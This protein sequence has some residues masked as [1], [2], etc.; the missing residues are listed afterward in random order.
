MVLGLTHLSFENGQLFLSDLANGKAAYYLH[1][2]RFYRRHDNTAPILALIANRSD[3][4]LVQFGG[5]S[6]YRRIPGYQVSLGL[7]VAV[8]TALLMLGSVLSAVFWIPRKL[9]GDLK[10]APYFSVRADPLL[11]TLSGVALCGLIWVMS[12]DSYARPGGPLW[13]GRTAVVIYYIAHAAFLSFSVGGL[14]RALHY[15]HKPISPLVWWHA[16]TLSLVLSAAAGYLVYGGL[17][18]VFTS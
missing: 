5:G 10:T 12:G 14:I 13:S 6:T 3:G 8:G 7:V 4:T 11:A 9:F 16:F 18:S 2:G 1:A 17:R 15:R